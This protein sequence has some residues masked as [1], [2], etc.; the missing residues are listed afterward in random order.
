MLE[1]SEDIIEDLDETLDCLMQNAN[2]LEE[3]GGN[4]LFSTERDA[5]LKTQESLL[6][7][8]FNMET[9]LENEKPIRKKKRQELEEKI[10]SFKK[11]STIRKTNQPI[12][13]SERDGAGLR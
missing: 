4:P 6:A 5:L 13:N 10:H 2:A 11:R 9:L 8:L 7:H 12:V 1:S 3:I